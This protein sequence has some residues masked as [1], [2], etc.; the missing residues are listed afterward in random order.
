MRRSKRLPAACAAV[1][2]IPENY[3]AP[4]DLERVFGR[5]A[6]VE[7]DIGCGDGSFLAGLAREKPERN[8]LGLERLL[9]RVRSA[10]RK[11]AQRDLN[12]ARVLRLE[13]SYAIRYLLPLRSIAVFHL[14]FPDPWP[15]RRHEPRRIVTPEF[16][17]SIHRALIHDGLLMLATDER[18]YFADMQ[19]L[20]QQAGGFAVSAARGAEGTFP[21]SGFEQRYRNKGV[22]IHRLVLRKVSEVR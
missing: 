10:C 22:K 20:A 15:K 7:V 13:S 3:F 6:A 17:H 1:E 21:Q 16:L 5:N 12:N 4:L 19:N 2:L 14:M 9:G 11:I 18:D 8:F